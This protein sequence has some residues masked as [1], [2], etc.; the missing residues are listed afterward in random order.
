MVLNDCVSDVYYIN[1]EK[2]KITRFWKEKYEQIYY[3]NRSTDINLIV[4]MWALGT[5]R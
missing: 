2:E 4:C 1:R 5:L 3:T